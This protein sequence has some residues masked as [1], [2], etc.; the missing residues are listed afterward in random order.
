MW[1]VGIT[2][3]S[4]ASWKLKKYLWGKR[5]FPG[6]GDLKAEHVSCTLPEP[7]GPITRTPNLLILAPLVRC[8][9]VGWVRRGLKNLGRWQP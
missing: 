4:S 9:Y 1:T 2:S 5:C 7:A 3:I 8:G 6:A